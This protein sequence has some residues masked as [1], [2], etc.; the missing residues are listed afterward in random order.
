MPRTARDVAKVLLLAAAYVVVA[1]AGLRLATVTRSVTLVWPSSGMSLAALLLMGGRFWPGVALGAFVTNASTPGVS[2]V[3]AAGMAVGNTVEALV[4]ATLL[5]RVGFAKAMDRIRDVLGLVVLGGAASTLASATIGVGSLFLSGLVTGAAVVPAWRT[6]WLG[7]LMGDLVFAPLLLTLAVAPRRAPRAARL[8]ELL[9]LTVALA[10]A[11]LSAFGVLRRVSVVDFPQAYVIFPLLVWAALRFGPRG[12]AAANFL[13]SMIS[14]WATV[15]GTGPF[16][17]A[18][19]AE[20]LFQL[21]AFMAIVVL[22]SLFLGAT[23]AERDRAIGLRDDFLALASHELN[24]PLTALQLDVASLVRMV[25]RPETPPEKLRHRAEHTAH[26][27]ERLH[28]LVMRLLDSSQIAAGQVTLRTAPVDLASVARDVTER[29][30]PGLTDAG[31]A[32]EL[33][34]PAPVVGQWDRE[35]LDLVVTNLVSNAIKYGEGK[36]ILV[37]VAGTDDEATLTVRDSGIGIARDEHARVFGRFA[38]AVSSGN[39]GGLGLGLWI[40]KSL[41]ETMR[42]QVAL[43][44]ERGAGATFTVTLPRGVGPVEAS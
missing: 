5:R 32:L 12:A 17:R 8:A 16:A 30:M 21:Q 44:S 37:R 39:Y 26:Q 13:V 35:R 14:I 41:V 25:S 22:T 40:T 28:E 7:D 43:D 10:V 36:P 29:F 20:S 19:L 27:V 4:A 42:G 1:K 3:V 23:V 24:T 18:P 31:H 6:W 33:D 15:A 2:V 38:R 9:A 34:A 11:S